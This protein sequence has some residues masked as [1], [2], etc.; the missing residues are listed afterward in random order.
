VTQFPETRHSLIQRLVN[1]ATNDDWR[2]FHAD[3]WSPLCPFA[4]KWGPLNFSDAEDL[5]S[6]AFEV[7]LTGTLLGRW[8]E[9]RQSRLRTMLCAVMKNLIGNRLRVNAGRDRIHREA[10]NLLV[11]LGTVQQESATPNSSP[12]TDLFYCGWVESILET[13][14]NT[15]QREYLR[16]GKGDYFRVLYGRACEQ[17]SNLE[18][19]NDLRLK[20][21]DVENYYRRAREKLRERLEQ[22]VSTR[23]RRYCA[24]ADISAETAEELQSLRQYLEHSGGLEAAIRRVHE[25]AADMWEGE[26]KSTRR[27]ANV[28]EQPVT[29]GAGE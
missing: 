13:T 28:L 9:T 29:G 15:I 8:V 4:M 5:A 7:L 27:L 6:Q 2:Q 16:E 20:V 26:C 18:I 12:E 24:P 3:Y 23:V 21:T 1:S 25:A 10:G 22:E 19:A 11:E 14:L 17:M